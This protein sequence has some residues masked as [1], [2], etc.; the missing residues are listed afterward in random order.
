MHKPKHE[1]RSLSIFSL[2]KIHHHRLPAHAR[3]RQDGNYLKGHKEQVENEY[4]LHFFVYFV[5][6]K[7]PST[8]HYAGAGA[9]SFGLLGHC[10]R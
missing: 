10:I 9:A 2:L 4:T 8:F 1:A 5:V 3:S 7:P 6:N